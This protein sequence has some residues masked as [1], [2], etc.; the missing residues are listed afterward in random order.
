MACLPLGAERRRPYESQMMDPL[1]YLFR[2][3]HI[4]PAV[5]LAGGI[6]FMWTS[7]LPGIHSL[8]AE[9]KKAV[10]DGVRGKWAKI[11]MICSALLLISGFYNAVANIKAYEYA[12]PYGAFVAVKL[13]LGVAIM[14]INRSSEGDTMRAF[15][16]EF[17]AWRTVR[18]SSLSPSRARCNASRTMRSARNGDPMSSMA[19]RMRRPSTGI[20]LGALAT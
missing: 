11:V 16:L 13:V 10:S 7:L 1:S 3:L 2:L 17:S 8:D 5:F 20:S 4:L 9:T 14:F 6:F 18:K 12:L 15:E 19:T